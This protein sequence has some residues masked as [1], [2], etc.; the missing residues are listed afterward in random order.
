M[1]TRPPDVH[2][3]I[4]GT[5]VENEHSAEVPSHV[6]HCAYDVGNSH[7]APPLPASNTYSHT[8]S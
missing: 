1:L 8:R 2:A 7:A 5:S 4:V 6:V 3:G